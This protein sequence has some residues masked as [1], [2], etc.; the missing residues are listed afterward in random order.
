MKIA[1][2]A[3]AAAAISITNYYLTSYYNQQKKAETTNSEEITL[4]LEPAKSVLPLKKELENASNVFA[5]YKNKISSFFLIT[6][7]TSSSTANDDDEKKS[8]E[9]TGL[10]QLISNYGEDEEAEEEEIVAEQESTI[11]KNVTAEQEQEEQESDEVDESDESDIEI[12]TTSELKNK[13]YNNKRNYLLPSLK[14]SYFPL[15]ASVHNLNE[16]NNRSLIVAE[17][18]KNALTFLG[19]GMSSVQNKQLK[20][21]DILFR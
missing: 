17:K 18:T 4:P 20:L 2:S 5:K 12:I 3:H 14:A 10:K 7:K 16:S 19:N 1:A 15:K 21:N 11:K 6:Q 9:K 13:T 8:N